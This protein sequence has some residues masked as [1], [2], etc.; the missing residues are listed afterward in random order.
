[1]QR[2]HEKIALITGG[3]RG[4]GFAVARAFL[5]EGATVAFTGTSEATVSRARAELAVDSRVHGFVADLADVDAP[6]R[7]I[8]EVIGRL[9]RVDVL[10]N[11]AA[12]VSR[13]SEWDLTP[14]EW[15]RV[16]AVNTR[17][18][19]FLARDC[20]RSMREAGGGSIINLSSIAG[21]T[22]GIAGSPVYG[23]SKA[24]VI[25]L[26]RSLAR[27]LAP[28][29][30]R[31]NC[32]APADIETDATANWPQELRDRLNA[33]TPLNRF[34]MVD[35]VTGAAVYFASDESSFVTGQTLAING[36]AYMG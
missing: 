31:V 24:A 26:T 11:N 2:L 9:G 16:F 14:S 21:Q 13:M 20:A 34:G 6:A 17:A 12:V 25:G 36:G 7:L 10:F 19:F 35:E 1:M 5:A 22:G 3:T 30:I 27:R 23:A 18:A 29:K 28:H 15:D 8:G 4:I 32:L 33:I